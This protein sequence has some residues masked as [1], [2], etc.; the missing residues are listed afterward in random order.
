MRKSREEYSRESQGGAY[1]QQMRDSDKK[2]GT[3]DLLENCFWSV[4]KIKVS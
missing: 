3:T 1:Q 2:E 4:M